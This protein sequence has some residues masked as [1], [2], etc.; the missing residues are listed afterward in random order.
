MRGFVVGLGF[1]RWDLVML[2]VLD[3]VDRKLCTNRVDGIGTSGGY[4]CDRKEVR[5]HL[6]KFSIMHVVVVGMRCY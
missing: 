5:S 1:L 2:V 4:I 3:P 6:C